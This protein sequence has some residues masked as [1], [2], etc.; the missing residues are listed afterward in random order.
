MIR[1]GPINDIKARGAS[2]L[3]MMKPNK[4]IN[5]ALIIEHPLAFPNRVIFIL[6]V[7]DVNGQTV[8]V[9]AIPEKS[10]SMPLEYPLI[11]LYDVPQVAVLTLHKFV[12]PIDHVIPSVLYL[13]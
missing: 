1:S 5:S 9:G 2:S 11:L 4:F 3:Q 8:L 7:D 10:D 13:S 6:L 12:L